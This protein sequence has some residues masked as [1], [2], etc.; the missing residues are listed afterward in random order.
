VH[1]QTI[2]REKV[3]S[4]LSAMRGH[5]A[6]WDTTAAEYVDEETGDV[7]EDS[8]T[9]VKYYQARDDAGCDV[10]FSLPGLIKLLTEALEPAPA[11]S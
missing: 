6:D 3:E 11:Q 9:E 2:D 8:S 5:V 4:V 7:P 10:L 1:G